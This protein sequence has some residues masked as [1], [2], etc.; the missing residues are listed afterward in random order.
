[1]PQVHEIDPDGHELHL[2]DDEG[3][4]LVNILGSHERI[5]L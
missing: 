1:M 5:P 4:R 2:L 3:R